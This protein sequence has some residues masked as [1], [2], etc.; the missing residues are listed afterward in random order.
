M[1]IA[2]IAHNF[3]FSYFDFVDYS[4]SNDQ[5]YKNLKS[6]INVSDIIDDAEIAFIGGN[7]EKGKTFEL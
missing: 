3:A 1:L 2:A 6:V 4:K 5:L 7:D